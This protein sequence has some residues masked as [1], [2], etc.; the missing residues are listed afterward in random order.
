MQLSDILV[1]NDQFEKLTQHLARGG[2]HVLTGVLGG[3]RAVYLHGLWSKLQIPVLVVADSQFHAQQLTEDLTSLVGAEHVVYFPT[4]ETISAQVAITSLEVVQA[5]V[6]ALEHLQNDPRAVVVTG[7]TGVTQYLPTVETFN[8]AQLKIDFQKT[9]Y[10]LKALQAQLIMMGYQRTEA[11]FNPGE[12][13]VRGSII[14]VYPLNHENPV[15]MD[16]FDTELDSLRYFNSEDQKSLDP[17]DELQ[18]LPVT[19]LITTPQQLKSAQT[20]FELAFTKARDAL[21]GAQKRHLTENLGP[22]IEALKQGTVLPEMRQYLGYLYPEKT[23]LMDYLPAD[24]L[25]V[26]D[27]YPRALE[28]AKQVERDT[29]EWWTD[30]QAEQLVLPNPDLG[31]PL[32]A[33]VASDEH[34]SLVL[35]P[36]ARSIGNLKQDSLTQMIV[37]PAQQFYNQMPVLKSELDRWQKQQFTVIFLTNTGERQEKLAQT[38]SDFKITANQVN[39]QDYKVGRTQIG[40]LEL[41]G[42]F[43]IPSLKLVVLTEKEIFQT[44]VKR[45]PRRQTLSNAER[46]KSYNELKVGDYVV[47]VNH[48]IGIYQGITTLETRG[49]KQDYITIQYQGSGKVFIPITQLDLVQKYVSA[50]EKAPKLNKLGGTE[51]AKAKRKVAAKVEDIADELLQLYAE[52]EAKRGFAFSADNDRMRQFE[53]AFPYP[54]TLDQLQATAEI[55][56]DMEKIQPMDRLLVGDVGFGKTEVALRAAFKALNDHK[57]VA[58]LVPTTILAQQH[59]ESIQARFEGTGVKVAMLSRFQTAKET[60][61]ITQ[62]LKDHTLD[63]VVGTHKILSKSMGFDDLGLLIIDEE[64]RFGVK[65]KERLKQLKT[66]VD[67]LTLTA[68][69]IPRTLNMAMVGARDLSVLETPPANRFPIQTY[70]MEQ[71]GREIALAIEREMARGGQTFYLHNRVEDIEKARAYVESLVP[72]ARVAVIHGRMTETQLEGILYDFI[73][74]DYDVLVTTTIIET[75]VDIPNANTL[76]VES[77]DRMGLAQLYQIRGRVGRSYNLAY[78]YFMYPVNRTLSEVGEH[79]LEAIRDFTELGS[80]FKIAMRDLSIRG[81]GDLLGSQQH[82]FI[83]SVGYDLYTQMLQEAVQAKQGKVVE[84]KK[85]DAEL[86]LNVE[87]YLPINYIPGGAQKIE[88]YQRISR[89]KNNDQ[90][91]EI[92]DDLLDRYGELP[93]AA[94]KLLQVASIKRYAD[95]VGIAKIDHDR[96]TNNLLH[97]TFGPEADLGQVDW[98]KLLEA[99]HLRGKTIGV[100]PAR[101]D[102]VIQPKMTEADWLTGLE[103]FL[104]AL[105]EQTNVKSATK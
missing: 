90:F 65:H 93:T 8:Q 73:Q 78:A 19:D 7:Y 79:R 47:H 62:A 31:T 44:V 72:D 27:D 24:G 50:G 37:R 87:A 76:I 58:M 82:G 32:V 91:M 51:W 28:N 29:L 96:Q 81:A 6:E 77:A 43:E 55:K 102:I 68:T 49:V 69:P 84:Q 34:R 67:V 9:D 89:A 74:G 46:I 38:F 103:H 59:F 97:V 56:K 4:E 64:Q 14:D 92:E 52:R 85:A 40:V 15:R 61:E 60:R 39:N 18:I 2:R 86:N 101:I 30:R 88:F 13:S 70:V 75:G 36:L 25:L 21:E 33:G 95:Q 71:N 94:V 105:N 12:F 83:N 53:A 22:L 5:R 45:A 48:G 3:A 23:R 54:E 35:S 66:S 98:L 26:L 57:Q 10:D 80:G 42:G 17:L 41:H 11:V 16:F 99:Q 100:N 104:E 1:K 20:N 63:M